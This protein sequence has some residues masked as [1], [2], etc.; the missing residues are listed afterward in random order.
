MNHAARSI[1]IEYSQRLLK[2]SSFLLKIGTLKNKNKKKI[3]VLKFS[4][5]Q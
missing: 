1:G 5:I 3:I 2:I 4:L